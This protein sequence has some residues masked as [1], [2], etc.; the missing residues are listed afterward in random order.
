[1]TKGKVKYGV[2][3]VPYYKNDVVEAKEE[4]G[5]L[6]EILNENPNAVEIDN[7]TIEEKTKETKKG[8]KNEKL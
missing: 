6:S 8:K 3:G 1:M 2:G 7:D 4:N 5:V